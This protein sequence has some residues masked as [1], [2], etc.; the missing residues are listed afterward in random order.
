MKMRNTQ[1]RYFV[2]PLSLKASEENGNGSSETEKSRREEI[3]KKFALSDAPKSAPKP[4]TRNEPELPPWVY[5]A[6]PI[7]G[8]LLALALQVLSSKP[9]PV[10]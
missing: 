1:K 4:Q 10:G 3:L 7:S 8:A 5:I 6:V 9:L 2:H